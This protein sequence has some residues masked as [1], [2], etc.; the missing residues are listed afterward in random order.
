M[1]GRL[2]PQLILTV[3]LFSLAFVIGVWDIWAVYHDRGQDTVSNILG[4][5]AAQLPILPFMLG[6]LAGHLF[7]PRQPVIQ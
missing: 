1:G 3:M 2:T 7:W 4:L 6:L 5:W